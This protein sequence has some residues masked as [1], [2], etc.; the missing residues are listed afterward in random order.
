M[1]INS[2]RRARPRL[3][4]RKKEKKHSVSERVMRV[5]DSQMRFFNR[6]P[7]QMAGLHLQP[8]PEAPL[9]AG[10][11]RGPDRVRVLDE[12]PVA[13]TPEGQPRM[14]GLAPEQHPTEALV[15]RNSQGQPQ[16]GA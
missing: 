13:Q 6:S 10:V 15:Q 9:D 16:V 3:N 4:P 2:K 1:E 8:S 11:V 5:S 7:L 12:V 14:P